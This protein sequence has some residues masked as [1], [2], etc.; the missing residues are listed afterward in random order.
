MSN[1]GE[2]ANQRFDKRFGVT[3]NAGCPTANVAE[4]YVGFFGKYTDY[5]NYVVLETDYENY[6]VI[7]TC[8]EGQM[9]YLWFMSRTPVASQ[10]YMDHMMSVAKAN[11]PNFDFS[12]L[13]EPDVQ[14]DMCKVF[15]QS[16]DNNL[17]LDH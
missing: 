7:H 12:T 8:E 15:D 17:Y 3:G 11:L 1:T 6:S 9:A 4:C 16:C 5:P 14:G 13:A 2:S 10:K